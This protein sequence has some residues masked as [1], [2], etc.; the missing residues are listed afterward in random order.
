MDIAF[1]SNDGFLP[2]AEAVAIK[3]TAVHL[4]M[5]SARVPQV[6]EPSMAASY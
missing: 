3:E 5:N 4:L 2:Y 6:V 1:V